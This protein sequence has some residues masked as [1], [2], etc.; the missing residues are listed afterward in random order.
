MFLLVMA[1]KVP[2]MQN[3]QEWWRV[4][5]SVAPGEQDVWAVE[6]DRTVQAEQP[7]HFVLLLAK[8]KKGDRGGAEKDSAR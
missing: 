3:C 2:G 4:A 8:K 6:M 7:E 5:A 1:V